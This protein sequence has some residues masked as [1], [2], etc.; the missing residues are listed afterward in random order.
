MARIDWHA[1]D[2][3]AIRKSS[4]FLETLRAVMA[5]LTQALHF[6]EPK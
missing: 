6:S 5:R 4:D 2:T 1:V 3:D